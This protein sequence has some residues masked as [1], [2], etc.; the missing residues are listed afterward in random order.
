MSWH[1]KQIYNGRHPDSFLGARSQWRQEG[2]WCGWGV[3]PSAGHKV[4]R[5]LLL[6]LAY[7]VRREGNVLTG[8]CLSVYRGKRVEG[9]P[10]LVWVTPPFLTLPSPLSP[11]PLPPTSPPLTRTGVPLPPPLLPLAFPLT[12]QGQDSCSARAICLLRSR[13]RTFLSNIDG[14]QIHLS[15]LYAHDRMK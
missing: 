12:P 7:V 10:V 14:T 3:R 2:G 8:I 5:T 1:S 6:L 15:S 11:L 9:T 13:R 4:V